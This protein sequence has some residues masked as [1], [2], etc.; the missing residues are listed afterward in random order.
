MLLQ[1]DSETQAE[2]DTWLTKTDYILLKYWLHTVNVLVNEIKS[3]NNVTVTLKPYILQV[4]IQYC[5]TGLIIILMHSANQRKHIL[6]KVFV[7][8]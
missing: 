2:M 6:Q 4:R 1:T 8:L 7:N 5:K 3:K